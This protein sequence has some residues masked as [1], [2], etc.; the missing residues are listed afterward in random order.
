[1]PGGGKILHF[2]QDDGGKDVQDDGDEGVQDDGGKGVRDDGDGSR[3]ASG[4]ER[5]S[6]G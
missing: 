4:C 1:V 6:E 3:I 2:V 5:E